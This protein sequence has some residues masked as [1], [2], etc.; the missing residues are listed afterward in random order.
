MKSNGEDGWVERLAIGAVFIAAPVCLIVF[1]IQGTIQKHRREAAIPTITMT[2]GKAYNTECT[3]E[4]LGDRKVV[5]RTTYRWEKR[6][7]ATETDTIK[8]PNGDE[9]YYL[10]SIGAFGK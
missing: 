4:D 7:V 5:L 3:V 9:A 10:Q 6:V 2:P 8:K 1:A